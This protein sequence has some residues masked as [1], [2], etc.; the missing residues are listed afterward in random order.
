MNAAAAKSETISGSSLYRISTYNGECSRHP[1]VQY[2][3]E[4]SS[5][6]L[7]C[8]RGCSYRTSNQPL[9]E[10]NG[11]TQEPVRNTNTIKKTHALTIR[12]KL[13]GKTGLVRREFQHGVILD[14]HYVVDE[15]ERV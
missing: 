4:S 7:W 2:P 8:L 15:I 13:D 9:E 14:G 12:V 6:I 1:E 11:A 10:Q 5:Y 3:H